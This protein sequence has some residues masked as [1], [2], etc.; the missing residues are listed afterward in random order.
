KF[1]VRET[2]DL[3]FQSL[4]T[5]Y[6]DICYDNIRGVT[7]LPSNLQ[8]FDCYV[9]VYS[10]GYYNILFHDFDSNSADDLELRVLPTKKKLSDEHFSL[11]SIDSFNHMLYQFVSCKFD[12][13]TGLDFLA[14]VSNDMSSDTTKNNLTFTYKFAN[15]SGTFNNITGN[16]NFFNVLAL[17]AAENKFRNQVKLSYNTNISEYGATNES[18]SPLSNNPFNKDSDSKFWNNNTV[19]TILGNT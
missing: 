9:V 7:V 2:L 12:F 14:T 18:N 6:K 4:I 5:T 10:A 13:E 1:T 19:K 11:D 8:K 3:M 16:D 15:S 17:A